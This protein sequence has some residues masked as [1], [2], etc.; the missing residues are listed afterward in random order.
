MADIGMQPTAQM[1]CCT[2][3]H[4]KCPMH[5]TAADCCKAEGQR[6]VAVSSATHEPSSPVVNPPAIVGTV[7]A[8]VIPALVQLSQSTF[9]QD[10]LKGPDPPPY[11][12]GSAFRV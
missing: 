4:D 7:A 5:N 6:H 8:A 9:D 1:A 2:A 3:G 12:L 11:L 10:I